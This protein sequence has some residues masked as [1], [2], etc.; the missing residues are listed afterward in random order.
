MCK[1]G[2]KCSVTELTVMSHNINSVTNI[3]LQQ[4]KDVAVAMNCV[5]IMILCLQE[6]KILALTVPTGYIALH[7]VCK[8]RQ[9]GG[10]ATLVPQALAIL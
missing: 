4:L 5:A 1:R 7:S 9:D 3:K 8:T 10:I 6:T 2:S